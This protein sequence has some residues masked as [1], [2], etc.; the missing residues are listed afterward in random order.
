M[1]KEN[2]TFKLFSGYKAAIWKKLLS[3]CNLDKAQTQNLKG[4]VLL[5]DHTHTWS[6]TKVEWNVVNAK[7]EVTSLLI[8]LLF[9]WCAI[10]YLHYLAICRS[11]TIKWI[12]H[13]P[14]NEHI[15]TYQKWKLQLCI[16]FIL[17]SFIPCH[18][19][20]YHMHYSLQSCIRKYNSYRDSHTP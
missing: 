1:S 9:I 11:Q 13:S 6:L 15:M 7:V 19:S 14:Q 8:P 17:F 16:T 3:S 2:Q 5:L 4:K 10:I 18:Y 20:F 12:M